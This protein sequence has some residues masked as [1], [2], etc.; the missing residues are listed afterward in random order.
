MYVDVVVS[1]FSLLFYQ[2]ADVFIRFSL[3]FRLSTSFALSNVR[4][5]NSRI[6]SRTQATVHIG[7][8][9]MESRISHARIA[10]K[11]LRAFRKRRTTTV[12]Q[13]TPMQV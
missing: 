13:S 5:Q 10:P 1:G 12:L 11:T 4:L 7:T 8:K 9:G 2:E 6:F 3:V